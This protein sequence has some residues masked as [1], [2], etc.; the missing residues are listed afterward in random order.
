MFSRQLW[1]FIGVYNNTVYYIDTG[2]L[3]ENTPLV[4]FIGNCIRVLS[5]VFSI[6]SLVKI[7]MTSFPAFSRLFV[8]VRSFVNK[9]KRTLH[10][11]SEI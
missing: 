10:V 2:V 7:S 11:S 6:S 8:F 9:I 1:C 5:G 3:L 4:K